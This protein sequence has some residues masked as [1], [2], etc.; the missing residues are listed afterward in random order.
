MAVIEKTINYAG[1]SKVIGT[2][3]E[4][5]TETDTINESS[6]EVENRLGGLMLGPIHDEANR[7]V[8]ESWMGIGDEG[9]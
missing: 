9:E 8:N 7:L 5:D 2:I 4:D 1:G 3:E 6:I